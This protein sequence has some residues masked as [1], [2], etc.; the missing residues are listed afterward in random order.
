MKLFPGCVLEE[1]LYTQPRRRN[2]SR[3]E[4]G[5]RRGTQNGKRRERLRRKRPRMHEGGGPQTR[6]A[7][8]PLHSRSA[9][10]S[11]R[12]A[13]FLPEAARTSRAG[14]PVSAGAAHAIQ[15]FPNPSAPQIMS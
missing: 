9:V 3:H 8:S 5:N 14:R 11:G 7:S 2:K 1:N 13:S 4:N 12:P 10:K 15:K 6:Y